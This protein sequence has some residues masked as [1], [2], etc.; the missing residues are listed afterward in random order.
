[1]QAWKR[2]T[3]VSRMWQCAAAAAASALSHLQQQQRVQVAQQR[4]A[5]K[6]NFL[7]NAHL[8]KLLISQG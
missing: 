1:M 5:F 3:K 2:K 4:Q 7:Q 8:L 6:V